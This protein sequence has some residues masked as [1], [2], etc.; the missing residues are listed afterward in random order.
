MNKLITLLLTLLLISCGAKTMNKDVTKTDSSATEKAKLEIA[1]AEKS[2]ATAKTQEQSNSSSTNTQFDFSN[3]MD[4]EPIDPTKPSSIT[5]PSGKT[6][7]FQNAKGSTNTKTKIVYQKDTVSEKK[8]SELEI[9]NSRNKT[10]ISQ[11]DKTIQ[12]LQNEVKKLNQ[13]EQWSF[14]KMI[15]DFGWW[16]LLIILLIYLGYK[17]VK[18]TNPLA[19]V[20]GFV[21]KIKQPII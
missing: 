13:R 4:F 11:K 9:E 17:W 5:E 14:K 15:I 1:E 16:W 21:G 7:V 10:L 6:T 12:L 19:L 20:N 8:V 2:K 3:G 18:G